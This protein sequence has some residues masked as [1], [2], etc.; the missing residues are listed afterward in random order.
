MYTY[1]YIDSVYSYS[2]A[3]F[4]LHIHML[5]THAKANHKNFYVSKH[6][7]NLRLFSHVRPKDK[8][9]LLHRPNAAHS[10]EVHH[11]SV[12]PRDHRALHA[13]QPSRGER[14]HDGHEAA[15]HRHH[16]HCESLYCFRVLGFQ[17]FFYFSGLH[18]WGLR[19]FGGFSFFFAYRGDDWRIVRFFNLL[20]QSIS[21]LSWACSMFFFNVSLTGGSLQCADLPPSR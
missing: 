11:S 2:H 21:V 10:Q 15:R 19:G 12:L 8:D 3:H 9:G 5:A 17:G 1:I 14:R 16:V 6:D 13:S 20:A 4:C 7:T 18:Y